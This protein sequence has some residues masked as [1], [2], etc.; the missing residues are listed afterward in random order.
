MCASLLVIT[1]RHKH[2]MR[3]EPNTCRPGPIVATRVFSVPEYLQCW[4]AADSILAAD[5]AVGRAVNLMA[6]EQLHTR[7]R[8]FVIQRDGWI[9][10][11]DNTI[12]WPAR[13]RLSDAWRLPRTQ[14]QV[15]Y[16]GHT[17]WREEGWGEERGYGHLSKQRHRFCVSTHLF[18]F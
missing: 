18:R 7:C 2:C 10:T 6:K 11:D 3:L 9:G 4:V 17:W 8:G 14:V 13:R 5:V 12:P 16:N 1:W 15:V